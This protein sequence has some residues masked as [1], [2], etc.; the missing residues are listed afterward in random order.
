MAGEISVQSDTFHVHVSFR[1]FGQLPAN[2]PN[3]MA[4]LRAGVIGHGG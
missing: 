3:S 4:A 1:E 2:P